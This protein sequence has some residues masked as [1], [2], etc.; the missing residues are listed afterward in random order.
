MAFKVYLSPS[1]QPDNTYNGVNTNERDNC[2]AIANLLK[3]EL[4]FCGIEVKVGLNGSS[5]VAESNAFKPNL[6]IPIHT[7]AFNKK[8]RGTSVMVYSKDKNNMKYAEPVF[9]ALKG[10]V[11]KQDPGRG[12]SVRTDLKELNATVS[13]AVYIEVDFHDV[14]EVAVWLTTQR[15]LIAKTIAK[16]ICKAAGITYKDKDEKKDNT[17]GNNNNSVSKPEYYAYNFGTQPNLAVYLIK[18]LL[19]NYGYKLDENGYIGSGT[20]NALKDIFNK[21]NFKYDTKDGKVLINER[22]CKAIADYVFNKK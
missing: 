8:A 21:M 22:A 20:E 13:T 4:V 10:I 2:R 14:K 5:N 7:N 6:H 11:L 17:N 18:L 12:I 3:E 9:N 1:N 19:N 16:A 15:S